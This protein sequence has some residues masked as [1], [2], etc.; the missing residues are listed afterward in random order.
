MCG[1]PYCSSCGP[2]QGNYCCIACGRWSAD[3]PCDDPADCLKKA[4]AI[5]TDMA[6]RWNWEEEHADE[7][8]KILDNPDS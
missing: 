5:E 8:R 2:A 4:L 7:I 6:V 3:G 1:D